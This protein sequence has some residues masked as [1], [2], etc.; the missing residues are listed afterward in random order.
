M[1]T[2]RISFTP[3]PAY[4]RTVRTVAVAVARRAGVADELLD[5]VRL[6]VGEACTRAIGVHRREG[7]TD[8]IEVALSLGAALT[9]PDSATAARPDGRRGAFGRVRATP[10]PADP[11]R[12]TVGVTDRGSADAARKEQ[13][14]GTGDIVARA[15]VVASG[16][17]TGRTLL[18][19]ELL[20]IG[21]GLA[22]LG[23]LA[24]DLT[25]D[26][27]PGGAGTEVRMSWPVAAATAPVAGRTQA[28]K[29]P[30]R[31]T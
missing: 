28:V 11:A 24:A 18:E 27:G 29:R 1:P 22:L 8:P 20:T 16:E 23:G 14:G 10:V 21:V 5:E 30:W 13:A 12:F 2:V 15:T 3:D 7:R 6:A 26:D 17:D 4:V 25:V 9:T 31:G 19:E